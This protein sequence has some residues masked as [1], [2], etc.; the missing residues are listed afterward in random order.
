MSNIVIMMTL[1]VIVLVGFAAG[2]LGYMGGDFD[3]RLSNIVI[4]ITCPALIL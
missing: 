4:D 3:K 1:F 2:K